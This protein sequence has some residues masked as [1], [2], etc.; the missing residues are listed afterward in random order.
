MNENIPVEVKQTMK[1]EYLIEPTPISDFITK[2]LVIL[3]VMLF[4]FVSLFVDPEIVKI[5]DF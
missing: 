2:F 3:A 5:F 1:R 4:V